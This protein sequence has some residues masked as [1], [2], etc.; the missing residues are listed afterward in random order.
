MSILR[1]TQLVYVVFFV[2]IIQ[3]TFYRDYKLYIMSEIM[4][5]CNIVK[6]YATYVKFGLFAMRRTGV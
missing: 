5:L 4:Q 2:F 1:A 6:F 3:I